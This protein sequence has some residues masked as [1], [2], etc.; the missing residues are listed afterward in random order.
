[1]CILG[2]PDFSSIFVNFLRYVTYVSHTMLSHATPNSYLQ[3]MLSNDAHIAY[4][5]QT[6]TNKHKYLAHYFFW[7]FF[8]NLSDFYQNPI[9]M[10]DSYRILVKLGG[11]CKVLAIRNNR[12]LTRSMSATV[13]T[14]FSSK[15]SSMSPLSSCS[16]TPLSSRLALLNSVNIEVI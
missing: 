6:N 15:T 11:D 4:H 12:N 13:K 5:V 3:K 10:P 7:I 1:M 2:C 9:G 8:F 16:I 14:K